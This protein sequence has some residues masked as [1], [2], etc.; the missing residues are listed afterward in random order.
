MPPSAAQYRLGA[1]LPGP[2][3]YSTLASDYDFFALLVCV[4]SKECLWCHVDV[5]CSSQFP[6]C[7]KM[8]PNGNDYEIGVLST[9]LREC[10]HVH[11]CVVAV[12]IS[13]HGRLVAISNSVV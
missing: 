3:R 2:S 6:Y 5:C 1:S 8:L 13:A 11:V 7:R 12:S 10:K 4:F 9:C